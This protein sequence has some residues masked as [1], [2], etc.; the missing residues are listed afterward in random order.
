[1]NRTWL[2]FAPRRW[3]TWAA[4][5]SGLAAIGLAS[6]VVFP[7]LALPA[8]AATQT[9]PRLADQIKSTGWVPDPFVNGT[10]PAPQFCSTDSI[11]ID[12]VVNKEVMDTTTFPDGTTVIR[13]KGQLVVSFTNATTL[14]KVVRD[15]SGSTVTVV[16]PDQLGT[17]WSTGDNFWGFG[18]Q[19]QIDTGEPGLVF[20]HGPVAI[21]FNGNTGTATGFTLL[22]TQVNACA[23]LGAS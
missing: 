3:R 22:G 1:M 8:N 10:D 23:L 15:E 17:E 9:S 18:P 4:R 6:L 2:R 14:K 21:D 13:V 19:S 5:F 7:F 16:F 12:S 11:N 20:T